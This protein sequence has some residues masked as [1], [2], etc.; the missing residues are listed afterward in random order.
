MATASDMIEKLHRIVLDD[1]QV[2]VHEGARIVGIS[3][4]NMCSFVNRK[5]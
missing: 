5:G 1:R 4:D 2:K 3:K